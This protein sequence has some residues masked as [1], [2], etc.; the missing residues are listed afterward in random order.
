MYCCN[1]Q[2][3]GCTAIVSVANTLCASLLRLRFV[4]MFQQHL[5]QL[6]VGLIVFPMCMGH[7]SLPLAP[8]YMANGEGACFSC[9][10]RCKRVCLG[11]MGVSSLQAFIADTMFQR[12]GICYKCQ[13]PLAC[14][15]VIGN[16]SDCGCLLQVPS[17]AC[18]PPPLSN[19]DAQLE[20]RHVLG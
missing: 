10:S 12:V 17:V 11:N 5:P 13:G 15:C 16:V 20:V 9:N 8:V 4:Y 6:R 2:K 3:R 1:R 7:L 18:T 14:G 19:G